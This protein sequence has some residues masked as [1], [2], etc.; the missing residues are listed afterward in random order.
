[1]LTLLEEKVKPG[2]KVLVV[3]PS[4]SYW[5]LFLTSEVA[6]RAFDLGAEVTWLNVSKKQSKKFEVNKKDLLPWWRYQNLAKNTVMQLKAKGIRIGEV[7]RTIHQNFS[8]PEF[9]SIAEL[10][11]YRIHDINLGA[12]LFSSVSSALKTT[13]FDVGYIRNFIRHYLKSADYVRHNVNAAISESRPDL[14]VTINDR[15]LGS[16]LTLAIAEQLGIAHSVVY[17][18]SEVNSIEFYKNSLYDS[19]EWQEK[20]QDHWLRYPPSDQELEAVKKRVEELAA[21]PSKDSQKYL[22]NQKSGHAPELRDK[23]VVFY[24]QSEYEHSAYFIP[25]ASNRFANQYEAFACLQEVAKSNG[26][27]LILKYH[28]YPRGV[29][30]KNRKKSNN[31]DWGSVRIDPEVIQLNEESQVDTYELIA[32]SDLN[33]VWSSTVGLESLARLRPTLVLGNTHW[34]N[35]EWG[36]HGWNREGIQSFF[37]NEFP[38]FDNGILIKWYWYLHSFGSPT[39]FARLDGYRLTIWNKLVTKERSL[40]RLLGLLKGLN[41]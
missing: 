39:R 18:G 15:I 7:S 33:V 37:S 1:M 21:G 4:N 41:Q 29:K 6:L 16:A 9:N 24:A 35:M 23:T 5:S 8:I 3:N 2:S 38:I 13:S 36:I 31:L 27:R 17:F 40:F 22:T 14:I 25:E 11:R 30:F 32:N 19:E 10:R 34:L 28:P 20:V 26:Y 12:M